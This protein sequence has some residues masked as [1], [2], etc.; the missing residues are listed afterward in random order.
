MT[1]NRATV[2][3]PSIL[4]IV[5]GVAT[6][7]IVGHVRKDRVQAPAPTTAT[8]Q[9]PSP[10]TDDAR[11]AALEGRLAALAAMQAATA[12]ASGPETKV[13]PV[14]ERPALTAEERRAHTAKQIADADR[15]FTSDPVDPKWT[16]KA[17]SQLTTSV[18]T[19]GEKLGYKL[20]DAECRTQYCRATLRWSNPDHAHDRG[21]ELAEMTIPGLNCAQT[22]WIPDTEPGATELTTKLFLDCADLRAGTADAI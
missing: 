22:S 11:I 9:R 17:T 18:T 1:T 13:E 14:A 15:R 8:E 19:A 20:L 6:S 3:I 10:R 5:A 16:P 12:P 2:L 21:H 7:A 4:G